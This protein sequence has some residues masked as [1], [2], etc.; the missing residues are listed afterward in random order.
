MTPVRSLLR[1]TSCIAAV[2]V[3]CVLPGE[4]SGAE[5]IQFTL[6]FPVPYRVPLAGTV[7]PTIGITARDQVLSNPH[8]RLESLDEG[9]VRVDP[10]GRGLE[11]VAR[12]TASV[13]AAYPTAT[14]APDTV[15]TVLVVVSRIAVSSPVASLT[16]LG[17]TTPLRATAYD[18]Q[19]AAVPN[20][21]F[22]WS[23]ADAHVATVDDT[24]LVRA[25]DEGAVAITAEA[26]AV[27]GTAAVTV[28][29]AA[30]Q[31]LILPEVDTLRTLGRS[32]RFVA[33][34]FD[35]AGA[36]MRSAKPQW[37]SSSPVVARV[38]ATGLATADSA[39]VARII[40][41]VGPAAD[42][43][44]LVVKQVLRFLVVAP[45]LDTLVA[46]DDT[47][48]VGAI[49]RDS[50]GFAIPDAVV[51]WAINDPTI[52]TVDQTGLVR[53]AK[54]GVVLVTAAS[55]GQ[56]AFATMVVRQ[57]VATARILQD[58]VTL[59]GAGDTAHLIAVGLDRN[60]YAVAGA[61]FGWTSGSECVAT[62]D[63]A[64]LVTA[65]G[66]GSTAITVA[67]LAGGQSD[68]AM[69][70]VTGTAASQELIAFDSQRGI[71]IAR[72]DGCERITL[73]E[74]GLL[75]N[76]RVTDPA[77]SPDGG[78]LAFTLHD[79]DGHDWLGCHIYTARPDGSELRPIARDDIGACE[80]GN[81]W[82]FPAWSPDGTRIAVVGGD[83]NC[84]GDCGT[85][86]YV[87]N[88]DGSDRTELLPRRSGVRYTYPAW[89]SDGRKLAFED[90]DLI[91]RG[92]GANDISIVNA[93]GS[94][95]INLTNSPSNYEG[96]PAWSPDGLQLAFVRDFD[97]WVMNP[98]GS[99][100]RNLTLS[101]AL[102]AHPA[103]SPDG[104][105]IVFA[106]GDLPND[107]DRGPST[108]D[109]YV[110]NIDGTG[111]RRLTATAEYYGE[112]NPSWRPAAPAP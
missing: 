22:S 106:S 27:L 20:V 25:V 72:A 110:I 95:L 56:S 52:A 50:L 111:L 40:A 85:T 81:E 75:S 55:G 7:E 54:N 86:V 16:R 53:A 2:Y 10:T 82:A 105:R 92:L 18:A 67:P 31:V 9:V 33:V 11:G 41:R 60:G 4:P 70:S 48:R 103:W 19:D 43:A 76:A 30:A 13:R 107:F 44:T 66:D 39:G 88:A 23:S 91:T 34:A 79:G 8:Y 89:S 14:G 17:A 1:L 6:D 90:G 3:A 109:L 15:F 78:R 108:S 47:G 97:I 5:R 69:V 26:D 45:G 38:D 84:Y 61:L 94:G 28:T 71:E 42:T 112:L 32:A 83:V 77:W 73:I 37:T 74:N 87:L 58:N 36:M 64:G 21:A 99:G 68:I 35:S 104:S 96:Q 101:A 63:D 46:I 93:D 100:A 57:E 102:D 49:A 59:V 51:T 29:Q 24:G 80:S 98:D 12:G 65:R 62:V